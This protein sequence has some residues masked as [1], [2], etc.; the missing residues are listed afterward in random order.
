MNVRESGR[1]ALRARFYGPT[2]TR[3][4]RIRVSRFEWAGAGLDPNRFSVEWDYSLSITENYVYAV[5]EYVARAGWN[6]DWVVTTC[7]AGAV[8]VY[9]GAGDPVG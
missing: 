5:R 6:G 3:G 4:A 2:N 9:A 1:V 7:D 8:A